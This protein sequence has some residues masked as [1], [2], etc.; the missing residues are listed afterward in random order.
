VLC[1]GR[2]NVP[3][4]FQEEYDRTQNTE[5]ARQCVIEIIILLMS[6]LGGE[7]GLSIQANQHVLAP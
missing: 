6:G 7:S 4:G 2:D 5:A 1:I 3:R